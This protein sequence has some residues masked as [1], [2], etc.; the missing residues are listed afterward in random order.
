MEML[1]C[2]K[3]WVLNTVLSCNKMK[4]DSSLT[5]DKRGKNSTMV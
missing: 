3:M 1:A 5:V 2:S 4:R